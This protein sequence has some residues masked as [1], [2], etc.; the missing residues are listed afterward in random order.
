MRGIGNFLWFILGGG[1]LGIAWWLWGIMACVTVV[2]IPWARACFVI[3]YFTMFPFG[4]VAISRKELT[5]KVDIGT[6]WLGVV[7]NVTWFVLAGVWLA[8]GHLLAAWVNVVTI[9]GI[10]FAIQH[11]K[12]ASIALAPIGQT[13][14]TKEV[15][16]AARRANAEAVVAAWRRH[17]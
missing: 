12:L 6:G 13:I 15:A 16:E 10:P 8:I 11:L 7:G 14:V 17:A 9:I 1:V 5:D 3:G 2:G 4:R